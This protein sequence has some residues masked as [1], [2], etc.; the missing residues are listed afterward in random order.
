VGFLIDTCARIDVE[1][2]ALALADVATMTRG[3]PVFLSPVTIRELQFGAE[4]AK[5]LGVRQKR[6]AALLWLQR[7]PLFR[8]PAEAGSYS[9]RSQHNKAAGRQ[10][11][12]RMQDLWLASHAIQHG[13]GPLTRKRRD[14]EDIPGLDLVLYELVERS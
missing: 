12:Y 14:F 2:G 1:R 8:L 7:N 11:R 4:I 6:L 3:E 9:V 10:H 13:C 5:D